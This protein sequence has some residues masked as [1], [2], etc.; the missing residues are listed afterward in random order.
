MDNREIK[1]AESGSRL[2]QSIHLRGDIQAA[3]DLAVEGKIEGEIKVDGHKL[4]VARS[5][6]VK[7]N[8][9][10]QEVIVE[11]TVAGNILAATKVTLTS[12]ASLEGD[13]LASRVS[14]EEG[15]RFKGA[16]KIKSS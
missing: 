12:Q 8:I 2:G 13:I 16:I 10:A 3:E 7:G 1:P 11:G 5:A 6:T 15:A 14:I 4:F 9:S